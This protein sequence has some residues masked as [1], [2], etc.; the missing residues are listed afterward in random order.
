MTTRDPE[1]WVAALR[2]LL[3]QRGSSWEGLLQSCQQLVLFG[4][5]AAGASRHGSDFDLLCVGSG[6]S[7]LSRTLDL[8]FVTPKEVR[9]EQWLGCELAGH[10][11]RYG[12]WLVGEPD[13]VHRVQSSQRAIDKKSSKILLRLQAVEEHAARLDAPYLDKYLTLTR[14]DLQRHELLRNG[15]P[16]PPTPFLDQAWTQVTNAREELSRLAQGAGIESKFLLDYLSLPERWKEVR[17]TGR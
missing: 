12:I 13:W 14:R 1:H 10:V 4:S 7:R 2:P 8:V 17:N 16:V 5:R 9:E 11:A 6:S 15:E 3:E